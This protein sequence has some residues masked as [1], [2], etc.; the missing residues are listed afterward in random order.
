V[1]AVK[2]VFAA[3]GIDV[4]DL[5]CEE[6]GTWVNPL[7]TFLEHMRHRILRQPLDLEVWVKP[8]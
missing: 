7:S 4:L 8:A 2:I 5:A 3:L 6:A 1:E